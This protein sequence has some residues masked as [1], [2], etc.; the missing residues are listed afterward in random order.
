[1][2]IVPIFGKNLFAKKYT[3]DKKNVF[4]KL[5]DFWNN[6]LKL[7]AFFEKNKNDL[8]NGYY[9]TL[10]IED[11]I[12]KTTEYAKEFK[13]EFKK[14]S[15]VESDELLKGLDRIFEPLHISTHKVFKLKQSKSK[16]NWLRI[17]GLKVEDD[18]YIITGGAIKLT[19][20]M[21]ERKHTNNELKMLNNV[22]KYL[23][24]RNIDNIQAVVKEIKI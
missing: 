3:G 2:E 7:D 1:M 4:R 15:N 18:T 13:N 9:G 8:V 10:T 12:F 23:I 19:R 11:A 17:Y 22:R 5:F 20:T 6:P 14:L 16:N 24:D 21:Q